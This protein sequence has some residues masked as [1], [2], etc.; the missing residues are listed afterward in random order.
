M[1]ALTDSQLAVI[2]TACQ[3]LPPEKRITLMERVVASLKRRGLRRPTDADIERAM[4]EGMRG[5]VQGAALREL[6]TG[7]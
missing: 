6:F 7:S 3:P 1:L 5:L 2:M 4:R